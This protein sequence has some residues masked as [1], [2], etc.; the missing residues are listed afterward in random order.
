MV[1]QAKQALA[2][3][4]RVIQLICL[5][6][7]IVF[8]ALI[9]GGYFLLL[10]KNML[11]A[12]IFSVLLAGIAW[13]TAKFLGSTERGIQTHF[14]LFLLLLIISAVGVFNNLM[15]N[16]E[17]RRIF[18]E[19]VEDTE[20]R[21]NALNE[22]TARYAE[23]PAVATKIARVDS[24]LGTLV[25]EIRN[26][27]NCGQGPEALRIMAELRED[28]PELR[29]LSG[30]WTD[31]KRNDELAALYAETIEQQKIKAPWYVEADYGNLLATRREIAANS[32]AARQTLRDLRT[33]VSLSY[34]SGLLK[35]VTPKL[36]DLGSIYRADAEKLSVYS[37]AEDV[38]RSL[39]LRSVE[40]LGEWSQ[41]VDL[42]VSRIDRAS[43]YIYLALAIFL[44]WTM[45][46]MFG[47]VRKNAIGVSRGPAGPLQSPWKTRS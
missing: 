43:T 41:L 2:R 24:L 33:E 25:N 17:G 5:F 32:E 36:E 6:Y 39:D 28:L 19:T 10:Q 42:V 22:A 1:S 7:S 30:D 44:D 47:L 15:L 31:C 27:A 4:H 9:A 38:P 13:N 18:L 3:S 26:P 34:A 12:L 45:V 16:L 8:V 20:K 29:P 11:V 37:R 40:N 14:P 46:Y 21:F 35:S 23:N